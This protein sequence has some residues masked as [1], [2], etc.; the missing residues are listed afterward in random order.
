MQPSQ[1]I[2]AKI[3]KLLLQ[4]FRNY[5][6]L[7]FS[8]KTNSVVIT[9]DNGVGKTN[10]LEAIS[11]LAPGRGLRGSKLSEID[12]HYAGNPW[13]LE[14]FI[15][16]YRDFSHIITGRVGDI[17]ASK[18]F[19]E[20]DKSNI[21]NQG[22]LS[23]IISVS[24]ITPQMDQV[25]IMGASVRRKLLDK[26]VGV[27]DIDHH[28]RLSGYDYYLRERSNLLKTNHYDNDWM[29]VIEDNIAKTAVIIAAS[30]VQTLEIIQD[31]IDTL[32]YKFS[33]ARVSVE[34][35]LEEK[36]S[37]IPA[38]QIEEEFKEILRN[39]RQID[40]LTKRTN[41][42]IHKSDLLVYSQEK[43]IKAE[44]CSTGEQKFL[45]ISIF[46]AEVFAQIRWK[47]RVPIILLDDILSHLDE[48]NR[49]LLCDIVVDVGAQ[50]FITGTDRNMF[51][52]MK[53]N[54]EFIN[55]ENNKLIAI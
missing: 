30:R 23:E 25:F 16:G 32:K 13:K 48:E 47:N 24:W 5:E 7:D 3:N 29:K 8:P 22:A 2:P 34:G 49:R 31:T 1:H 40:M 6:Y 37:K 51:Q 38:I 12:M 41:A 33:K 46:L 43:N 9:G 27:F 39:N 10:I 21:T 15:D 28:K 55:I 26:I 42:G 45:L 54:I 36:I 20:I 14:A 19:L 17:E 11:L 53:N 18:R 52:F 50:S 4:F 35:L 44:T